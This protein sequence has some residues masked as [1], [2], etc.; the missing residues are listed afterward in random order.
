MGFIC[1]RL[2]VGG[3]HPGVLDAECCSDHRHLR[4]AV[5]VPGLEDHP[6]DAGIQGQPGHDP[7]PIGEPVVGPD[8]AELPQKVVT[9]AERP[10]RGGIDKGKI[11]RITQ[12][13]RDHP[14]DDLS[15]VGA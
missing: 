2:F 15:Q 11:G 8:G 12:A 14:E 1:L 13:Q 4:E 9:V 6:G 5:P 10:R 3:A 7:A